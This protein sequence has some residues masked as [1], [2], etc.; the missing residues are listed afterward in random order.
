[1][2]NITLP[3]S[4]IRE[5][6]GIVILPLKKWKKLKMNWKIWRCTVLMVLQKRS[7]NH[8]KKQRERGG[9]LYL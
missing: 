7:R 2:P 1:M 6:E 9:K 3:K 4:A 5:K 8:E